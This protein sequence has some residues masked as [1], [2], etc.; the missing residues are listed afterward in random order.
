MF[1]Q[2]S[3]VVVFLCNINTP[4]AT[5]KWR[6]FVFDNNQWRIQD[7]CEGDA[8]GVWPPI[9]FGRD[10]PNFLRQIVSA[11][12]RN[13][14]FSDVGTPRGGSRIFGC[15]GWGRW[16]G[17]RPRPRHGKREAPERRG[18]GVWGGAP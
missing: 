12:R 4:R 7:F 3:A 9:F 17:Q 18:G 8:A 14:D 13:Q 1:I 16:R 15:V 11:H 5:K 6:H 2:L 10:D